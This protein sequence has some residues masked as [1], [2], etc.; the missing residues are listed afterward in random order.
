MLFRSRGKLRVRV[1]KL[2]SGVAVVR[3][4]G[5]TEVEMCER[6]FRIEDALNATRAAAEEGIVPGG[7]QALLACSTVVRHEC[8]HDFSLPRDTRSGM[9]ALAKAIEAPF[10]KIV[11]NAGGN[12]DAVLNE[13]HHVRRRSVENEVFGYNASTDKYEDLVK[14]GVIDPVKVS[15]TA[16]KNAV[17]VATT[18]LSLDAVIYDEQPEKSPD[19]AQ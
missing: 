6:R 1:A 16:L 14:A 3:V 2:A 4:G 19:P 10:R 11:E 9:L 15:R 5:A 8:D 13:L 12:P 18:F 17:S 7:G